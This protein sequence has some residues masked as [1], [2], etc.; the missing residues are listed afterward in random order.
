M[1]SRYEVVEEPSIS[2]A[3]ALLARPEPDHNTVRI[4][5]F[6]DP[7]YNRFDSR[8]PHSAPSADAMQ[9]ASFDSRR[10]SMLRGAGVDLGQLPRLPGSKAEAQAIT[11]IAGA[12]RVQSFLGFDATPAQV[13]GLHWNDFTIAHFAAHA[14]V[15][16]EHPELSEILLSTIDRYGKRQDGALWLHDIYRMPIPVTLVVLSGCGTA[17]GKSIPGEGISGLAQAFFSSGASGV[18][19]T[20]WSVDDA[21]TEQ[22]IPWFYRGLLQQHL[23]VSGALRTAHP[24]MLALHHP[25]YDWAGY[26]ANRRL[27]CSPE[28]GL[29]NNKRTPLPPACRMPLDLDHGALQALL[30]ALG[31]RSLGCRACL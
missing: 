1:V 5:V 20:L 29:R 16:S 23:T 22:M 25:T 15:D 31:Y 18:I 17:A 28:H 10:R 24:K 30:D 19:G 26:V 14:F 11:I 8:L 2:V 7:V 6:A 4:A 21:A 9:A 27:A 12:G 13:L 3:M